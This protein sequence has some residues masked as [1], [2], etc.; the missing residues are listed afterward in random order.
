MTK[1]KAQGPEII[2]EPLAG[3]DLT[4][5][6]PEIIKRL[7][8]GDGD[9]GDA[10]RLAGI[11]AVVV[12]VNMPDFLHVSR[13]YLATA[14]RAIAKGQDANKAFHLTGKPKEL[15]I[16]FRIRVAELMVQLCDDFGWRKGR[17]FGGVDQAAKIV[18]G[19]LPDYAQRW[20]GR[21]LTWQ[22][23]RKIYFDHRGQVQTLRHR[24]RAT[25]CDG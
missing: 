10:Q 13:D 12:A 24:L 9:K 21:S 3:A 4:L 18:A 15:P 22:A 5:S 25:S 11:L 6:V 8:R 16:D 14:L 20:G 7:E 19:R 23:V 17:Q 2:D 1:I